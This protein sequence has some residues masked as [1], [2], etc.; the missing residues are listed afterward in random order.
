MKYQ[1]TMST[2]E[3]YNIT[4]EEAINIQNGEMKGL[5]LVPSIQSYIN[6]SFVVSVISEDRIDK[7]KQQTGRLH[8]GTR[9]IKRF[10]E[11]KDADNPNVKLDYSHYPELAEDT[12]MTEEEYENKQKLLT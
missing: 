5:V 2:G 10:G 6:L 1:I 3:K 8:D 7:S 4:R 11:W 9:V 12:V